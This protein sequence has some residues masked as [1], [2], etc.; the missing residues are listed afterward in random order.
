MS[1][2]LT[3]QQ[4]RDFLIS[5]LQANMSTRSWVDF[6]NPNTPTNSSLSNPLFN[7]VKKNTRKLFKEFLQEQN[8]KFEANNHMQFPDGFQPRI[9]EIVPEFVRRMSH[10]DTRANQARHCSPTVYVGGG[11]VI[12]PCSNVGWSVPAP[13]SQQMGSGCARGGCAVSECHDNRQTLCP[14]ADK[15]KCHFH[16]T[17]GGCRNVHPENDP[18]RGKLP[19]K[20]GPTIMVCRNGKS[21]RYGTKC[22]FPHPQNDTCVVVTNGNVP[23]AKVCTLR[24][25]DGSKCPC[26]HLPQDVID[27]ALERK[28]NAFSK[29]SREGVSCSDVACSDVACS[30]VACSAVDSDSEA[31]R[32]VASLT[33]ELLRLSI[34]EP[35]RCGEEAHAS[36][37]LTASCS[38]VNGNLLRFLNTVSRENSHQAPCAV[39]CDVNS[40]RVLNIQ[41][42]AEFGVSCAVV[43]CHNVKQEDISVAPNAK[44]RSANSDSCPESSKKP[45]K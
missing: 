32:E 37:L 36:S 11:S 4:L 42:G 19:D 5:L 15:G 16:A 31:N 25:C 40:S 10:Q 29:S 9:S 26:A 33:A 39:M 22:D 23:I 7:T 27:K 2:N 35:P 21:C 28:K 12:E 18:K 13:R 8:V 34:E 44:K 45:R 41:S 14:Y 20:G 6:W 43:P 17:W 38:L 3:P 1:D 30:A 24:N